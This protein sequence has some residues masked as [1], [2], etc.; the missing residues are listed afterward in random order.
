MTYDRTNSSAK[1]IK[2]T[3]TA[4]RMNDSNSNNSALVYKNISPIKPQK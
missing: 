1:N 4:N 2:T 3:T